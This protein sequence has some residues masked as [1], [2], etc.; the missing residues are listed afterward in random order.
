MFLRRLWSDQSR[1]N[2]SPVP[3]ETGQRLCAFECGWQIMNEP[4]TML[5]SEFRGHLDETAF[6][7]RLRAVIEKNPWLAGRL[8]KTVD[9]GVVV[10]LPKTFDVDL[11]FAVLGDVGLRVDTQRYAEMFPVMSPYAICSGSGAL[12]RDQVLFKVF[13]TE[14]GD[15]KFAV[16][17]SMNHCIGDGHTAYRIF[18]ML[19]E[20]HPVEAMNADRIQ[21]FQE[22]AVKAA[23]GPIAHS[24]L[25]SPLFV[26]GSLAT[27][28]RWSPFQSSLA[29][30][31]PE[32]VED[33]KKNHDAKATGIPFLSTNDLLTAEL[34]ERFGAD[35]A[36][37]VINFR[38]RLGGATGNHA[39]NYES[40]ALFDQRVKRP[41][42]VRRLMS[43]PPDYSGGT[44]QSPGVLEMLRFRYPMMTNWLSIQR[45]LTLPGCTL[46]V[47]LPFYDIAG[48][49]FAFAVI[50]RPNPG[51]IAVLYAIRDT[52]CFKSLKESQAL[53][54][55]A[56]LC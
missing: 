46:I 13:H 52:N 43:N 39:G 7:E 15:G 25:N 24:F 29:T 31:R 33:Q 34:C 36:Y 14:T 18:G 28:L 10:T 30:V 12:D 51:K 45:D 42:E 16:L 19:G 20:S 55:S 38:D 56:A 2:Q 50:F 23:I 3:D 47:H 26:A 44:L 32:W 5:L 1:T 17:T 40:A 21:N 27:Y 48:P 53:D 41:E 37:M 35:G 22:Q 9:K 8:K 4:P 54:H 11:H 6:K 49:F